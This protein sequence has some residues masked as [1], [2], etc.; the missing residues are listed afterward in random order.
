[1]SVARAA[2]GAE[3]LRLLMLHGSRA[4]G[5]AR[6]NSD[7][8]FAFLADSSFDPDSLLARLSEELATDSIDL[9]DLTRASGLLR[10]T[11]AADGFLLFEKEPGLHDRFRLEAITAWCDM[12]PVLRPAYDAELSRLA[13]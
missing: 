8:D 12:E 13:K 10:F 9:A 6:P 11:A 2:E 5:S 3:G 7:W 1:M 4:R